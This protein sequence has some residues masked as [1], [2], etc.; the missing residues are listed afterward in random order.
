MELHDANIFGKGYH[1]KAYF[2]DSE[3]PPAT[4]LLRFDVI[5]GSY[6][7]VER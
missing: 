1:L 4:F 5:I 7:R 6:G 3:V 2:L